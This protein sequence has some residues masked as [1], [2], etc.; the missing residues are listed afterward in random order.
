MTTYGSE[1]FQR[2]LGISVPRETIA[3]LE[4][5]ER[6][7]TEWSERMN[8]VGPREIE[9]FWSRHAL[10]S[11]QVIQFAPEAKRWIDL[12]SGAG[13]PGLIVAAFLADRLDTAVHLV[14]STGKKAAFLRAVAGEAGLPVKVFNQRIED[15]GA[16]EGPYDVVTARALAP[17]NR[18]IPYAKPI[19]D[20]GAQ[21][22]FHKG[23]DLDAEL[24]AAKHVLNGGASGIRYRADVLESLSDPR[25]RI[26]RI[27]KA[28]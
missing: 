23:A 6:L 4:T 19:L 12:G 10:D 20:R 24:A 8:L 25:G 18:L 11:A 14:E 21:G 7:L 27:T 15:F 2:D 13:F 22:L 26:V 16:G 1:E 3:R 9:L 17:L 28:A 5:H